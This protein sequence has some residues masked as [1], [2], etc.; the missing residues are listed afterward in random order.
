MKDYI[1][2]NFTDDLSY[3]RADVDTKGNIA[4]DVHVN[5]D[6]LEAQLKTD[7]IRKLA[8]MAEKIL[9]CREAE[10]IGTKSVTLSVTEARQIVNLLSSISNTN[11]FNENAQNTAGFI[12]KQIESRL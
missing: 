11:I 2:F 4:M 8:D 5:S 9:S 6:V 10:N 12:I 1:K 3:V 7:E